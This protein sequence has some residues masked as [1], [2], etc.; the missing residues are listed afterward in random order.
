M[1]RRQTLRR[2][3]CV[4]GKMR[5]P[6]EQM[7]A[8]ASRASPIHA[9]SNRQPWPWPVFRLSPRAATPKSTATWPAHTTQSA[10]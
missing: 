7:C 10:G 2:R 4:I 9:R 3:S 8:T 5:A 1:A 6:G